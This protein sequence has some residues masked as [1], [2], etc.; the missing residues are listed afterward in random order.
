MVSRLTRAT[1]VMELQEIRIDQ[2]LF[3]YRE[4]HRLLQ[5]SRKFIPT[6]E[7]SLLTLTDMSGPRMVEGFEEYIS[8]YPVPG[9]E[10]YAVVKTWYAPEMERPGCV[11]S[12]A[13]IV[14]NED[15]GRITEI[16]SFVD[17]FQRPQYS[18]VDYLAP[19]VRP[20]QPNLSTG[21]ALVPQV[22]IPDMQ[23][24]LAA[25]YSKDE[26]PVII[27]AHDSR[28]L[29]DLVLAVWSQQWPALR[30]A[31]RFCSGA[32]S[33][34][35]IGGQTFDLQIIPQKLLP[36]LKRNP[37]G[38]IFQSIPSFDSV[39]DTEAWLH[40]GALDLGGNGDAFRKFAWRYA[41]ECAGG[42][43]LYAKLGDLFL[44]FDGASLGAKESALSEVARRVGEVFPDAKCGRA[45]KVELFGVASQSHFEG[46]G[47]DEETRLRQL[48]RGT[49]WTSFDETDLELH[50]RGRKLWMKQKDRGK[51]FLLELL[52]SATNPLGDDI[53]AGCVEV[54]TVQEVCEITKDRH[55]LLLAL[56]TRNPRLVLS[57]A[58]W[59]CETPVQTYLGILDFLASH[60]DSAIPATA[61]IPFL[62]ELGDDKFASS[63]VERFPKEVIKTLLDQELAGT[64]TD[65][66]FVGPGWRAALSR[67]QPELI[68]CLEKEAYRESGRAMA[69]LAGLLDPHQPEIRTRGLSPW[70]KLAKEIPDAV[71]SFPNGEAAAFLLS[72]GFQ[73]AEPEAVTLATTCFEHVHASARDDAREPLSYRAW[74]SLEVDV[75][76]LGYTKNWDHCERL[77]RALVE[78]FVQKGWPRD[79]FLKCV[80]RPTTLRSIFYSCLEVDRG[81][82]F[83]RGIASDVLNGFL[84][85]TGP[86]QSTF[87]EVFYWDRRGKLRMEL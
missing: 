73:S 72:V 54:M 23:V 3:G 82:D 77:R 85:A 80:N 17:L 13:L 46:L 4:G 30:A 20:A 49:N 50:D 29:E 64:D 22:S 34:R 57:N 65:R 83:I 2:A 24:L 9:D 48:A 41:E 58:F 86:Q 33:N 87:Q 71:L 44:Y 66:V 7:R 39:P 45:L 32:L 61:W 40:A 76:V 81:E 56:V 79:E 60:Q 10:S 51:T 75:P 27:P 78:R 36:E 67:H 15:I 18:D 19:Y 11:W 69:L 5:A 68:F 38:Y 25:L 14:R 8:G 1:A 42:R 59:Q 84:P 47:I 6:T 16:G 43:S 12:H 35:T 63:V 28:F 70:I 74:K 37:T 26:K 62:L 53:I 52:D 55:G 21:R 31:F